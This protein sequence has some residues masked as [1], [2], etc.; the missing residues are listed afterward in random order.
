M[1]DLTDSL[2][3][4]RALSLLAGATAAVLVGCGSDGD[5]GAAAPPSTTSSTSATG[6]TAGGGS[7]ATC[8]T[9]PAETVG[10]FPGDGTNGPDVLAMDGVVREDIRSSLGSSTV[11]DGVPLT[12][13]LTV[14]DASGC[15]PKPGAA[16]YVWHCDR[17]GRYSMYSS[18]AE[19]ETYLRGVQPAGADGRL[20]FTTIF[21]AAYQGRWPHIHFE[22]YAGVEDAT[23]GGSPIAISQLALPADVC[24]TV[25]ATAGYEASV[26]NLAR[27][28][29][30]SDMVFSDGSDHQLASTTGTAADG[31]RASLQIAV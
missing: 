16:V 8:E 10:P 29:L 17:E 14:L 4:R 2:T 9:I 6:G 13:D 20:S 28:S 11:A 23:G 1:A 25:Y 18:G 24:E 19:D 5:D 15:T 12:L 26:R 30:D 22:I 31:Y 21:P 3:R 27:T 7:D